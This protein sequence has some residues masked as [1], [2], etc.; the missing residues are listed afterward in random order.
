MILKKNGVALSIG[1][2]ICLKRQYQKIFLNFECTILN[3]LGIE[4]YTDNTKERLC[5]RYK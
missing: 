4:K 2:S 3:E 5:I 1:I